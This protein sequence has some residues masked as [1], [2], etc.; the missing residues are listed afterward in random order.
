ML[1]VSESYMK[2]PASPEY[3]AV[4][5]G[6]PPDEMTHAANVAIG[7]GLGLVPLGAWTSSVDEWDQFEWT[8]QR[9]LERRAM[10]C[11][12]DV[13]ATAKLNRRRLWMDAYLQWGRDT[14]GYATYLF[15]RP[16]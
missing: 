11:S 2:R 16:I 10:Q 14:L 13:E 15:Q 1:L 12:P 3:R 7:K 6:F 8:F 4:I 9:V 5:G